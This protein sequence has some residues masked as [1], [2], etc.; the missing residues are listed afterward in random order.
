M[1]VAVHHPYRRSA[2]P[3]PTSRAARG[4]TSRRAHRA[5]PNYAARRAIAIVFAVVLLAIAAVTVS[6]IVGAMADVGGRPAAASDI[7]SPSTPSVHVAR[8]GDTLW[9]IAD[10]HRGEVGRDRYVNALIDLNGGTRI[11]VAQA[12]LL[13]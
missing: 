10:L 9:S 8:S 11:E 5:R 4:R 7:A 3:R 13:P 6:A 12:V 2:T 1:T